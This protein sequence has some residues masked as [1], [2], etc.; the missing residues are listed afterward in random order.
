[1]KK[2]IALLLAVLLLMG[3][4]ACGNDAKPNKEPP[5]TTVT[6][7]PTV[8]APTGSAV[9]PTGTAAAPTGT[10]IQTEG[11]GTVQT[12]GSATHPTDGTSGTT[13]TTIPLP[14]GATVPIGTKPTTTTTTTPSATG[15]TQAPSIGGSTTE[16][17][18]PT[19]T[20]PT[21]VK[22]TKPALSY[23]VQVNE[24]REHKLDYLVSPPE[25]GFLFPA[26]DERSTN[27][28]NALMYSKDIKDGHEAFVESVFN[29]APPKC[30]ADQKK[31]FEALVAATKVAFSKEKF[32]AMGKAIKGFFTKLFAGK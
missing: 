27:L 29:I 17:T 2:Y 22:P 23:H 31:S 32:A 20:T 9:A 3:L 8:V 10:T 30:A 15:T 11:S 25:V 6:T 24:F 12:T 19:T 1:M 28:Y 21:T 4:T 5:S 18:T 13:S 26:F 14:T 16:A 7:K